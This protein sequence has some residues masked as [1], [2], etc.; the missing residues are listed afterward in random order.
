MNTSQKKAG[1]TWTGC[2]KV[3]GAGILVLSYVLATGCDTGTRELP[4]VSNQPNAGARAPSTDYPLGKPAPRKL[5][6]KAAKFAPP[7]VDLPKGPGD[8]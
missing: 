4:V 2:S 3:A 5:V 8:K 6:G 1:T 7:R